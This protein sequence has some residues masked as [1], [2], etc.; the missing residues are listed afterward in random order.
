MKCILCVISVAFWLVA[1]A[2]YVSMAKLRLAAAAVA[3]LYTVVY[4]RTIRQLNPFFHCDTT[5]ARL[6]R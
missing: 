1:N 2:P 3:I 5:T 4:G 6:C